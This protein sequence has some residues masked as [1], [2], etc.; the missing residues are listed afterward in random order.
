MVTI[1]CPAFG[2]DSVDTVFR[3]AVFSDLIARSANPFCNC[4]LDGA[5]A[6]FHTKALLP[7][8]PRFYCEIPDRNHQSIPV[9]VSLPI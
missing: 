8:P 2:Y 6:G 1:R 4:V 7:T 5:S 3:I 9:D